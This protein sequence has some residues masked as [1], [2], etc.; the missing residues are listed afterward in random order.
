[1]IASS[2]TA[3]M[4]ELHTIK[5][6]AALYI[7]RTAVTQHQSNRSGDIKAVVIRI[8]TQRVLPHLATRVSTRGLSV[9]HAITFSVASR[10][11]NGEAAQHAAQHDAHTSSGGLTHHKRSFIMF[12]H[13]SLDNTTVPAVGVTTDAAI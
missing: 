3:N 5:A 2:H 9:K 8:I 13:S 7:I 10:G 6:Y 1:M 4:T 11:F 12:Q